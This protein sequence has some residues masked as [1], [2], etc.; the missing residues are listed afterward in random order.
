M[1]SIKDKS[2]KVITRFTRKTA[3]GINTL[4]LKKAL[5]RKGKFAL[6]KGDYTITI[7]QEKTMVSHALLVK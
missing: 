3:Q 4:N 5:L 6:K 1:F 7:S 2:G